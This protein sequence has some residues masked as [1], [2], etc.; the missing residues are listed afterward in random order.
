MNNEEEEEEDAAEDASHA[1]SQDLFETLPQYTQSH[2]GV[3]AGDE[4]EACAGFRLSVQEQINKSAS[5]DPESNQQ[6]GYSGIPESALEPKNVP[7]HGHPSSAPPICI[8][9]SLDR[10][11][12]S[13]EFG[14]LNW[15]FSSI[16]DEFINQ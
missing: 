3:R 14:L 2:Q 5:A 7:L 13:S 6:K 1:M 16:P 15:G 4:K 8:N 11:A 10:T 9:C 12:V